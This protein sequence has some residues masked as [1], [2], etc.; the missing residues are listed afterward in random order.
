MTGPAILCAGEAVIDLIPEGDLLRPVPG[1]AAFNAARAAARLGAPT[2]FF[3]ALSRDGFGDRLAAA[4]RGDGVDLSLALR[5]DAPTP[6]SIAELSGCDARYTIHDAATAGPEVTPD[7]LPALPA[8]V[9]ALLV[10]G[11]SLIAPPAAEAFET[12]ALTRR[13]GVALMVDLNI[14]PGLIQDAALYRARLSRL[15]AAADIVKV[16]DEDLGW[17]GAGAETLAPHA[18]VLHTRGA[19]GARAL[20]PGRAVDVPAPRVRV[21]DTVGAG[22]VFDAAWLAFGLGAGQF[23]PDTEA[24]LRAALEFACRAAS[25]SCTRPGATGPTRQEMTCAPSSNA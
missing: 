15:I 7:R 23:A 8:S 24:A 11:F 20:R 3:G 22:D 12:L 5:V 14:R 18:L 19:G 6:I 13:P 17:L 21:A 25:L 2:G 16:S 1:G 4:A 9:R 10:G